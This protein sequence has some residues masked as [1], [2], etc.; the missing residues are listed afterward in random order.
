MVGG[1]TDCRAENQ[2]VSSVKGSGNENR[3]CVQNQMAGKR[4]CLK[5]VMEK[6][7]GCS[8]RFSSTVHM[9]ARLLAE[10]PMP[11]LIN[12]SELIVSR[13]RHP[14][15]KILTSSCKPIK[16]QGQLELFGNWRT[17]RRANINRSPRVMLTKTRQCAH[18]NNLLNLQSSGKLSLNN[19]PLIIKATKAGNRYQYD[20]V[21]FGGRNHILP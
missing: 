11:R 14:K 7:R 3:L 15:S 4:A 18:A 20:S 13:I 16:C 5:V 19:L 21:M 9:G 1:D 6:S 12:H 10:Y 17:T 2:A 8:R